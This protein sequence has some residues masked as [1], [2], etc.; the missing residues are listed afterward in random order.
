MSENVYHAELSEREQR[1][2]VNVVYH[3]CTAVSERVWSF[4]SFV[5]QLM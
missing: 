3:G 1:Q 2:C 5:L 4:A